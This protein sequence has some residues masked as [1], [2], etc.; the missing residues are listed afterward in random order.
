MGSIN[1]VWLKI[2]E[3][4]LGKGAEFQC[5]EQRFRIEIAERDEET[6]FDL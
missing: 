4:R 6:G 2:K 5:G 3:T 1:G